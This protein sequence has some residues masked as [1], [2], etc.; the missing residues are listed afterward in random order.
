MSIG[1]P[2]TNAYLEY[3][4]KEQYSVM[5]INIENQQKVQSSVM[6]IN[7]SPTIHPKCQPAKIQLRFWILT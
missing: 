1:V 4:Q 6:F 7:K 2:W 3:Q 5:F